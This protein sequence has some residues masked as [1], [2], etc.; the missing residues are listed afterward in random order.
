VFPRQHLK[1]MGILGR[2]DQSNH[3]ICTQSL[4]CHDFNHSTF[5]RLVLRWWA[6]RNRCSGGLHHRM[7]SFG[8]QKSS[9]TRIGE[10]PTAIGSRQRSRWLC[11][12]NVFPRR[13]WLQETSRLA[14]ILRLCHGLESTREFNDKDRARNPVLINVVVTL[15]NALGPHRPQ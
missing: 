9:P 5:V 14:R 8:E 4:R 13:G 2:D 3:G 12:A 15:A 1:A 6:I 10:R 7:L 11:E